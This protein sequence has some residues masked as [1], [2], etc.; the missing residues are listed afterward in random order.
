M[1]GCIDAVD[2]SERHNLAKKNRSCTRRTA[3]SGRFGEHATVRTAAKGR[4]TGE[5]AHLVLGSLEIAAN[6]QVGEHL[7]R[8][9]LAAGSERPWRV[10]VKGS[11]DGD[12]RAG[13][14]FLLPAEIRRRKVPRPPARKRAVQNHT[15]FRPPRAAALPSNAP[16]T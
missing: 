6:R 2:G 11:S 14:A 16:A 9:V 7:F 12:F 15:L 10:R 1:E 5:A 8:A 13:H 3:E 4:R